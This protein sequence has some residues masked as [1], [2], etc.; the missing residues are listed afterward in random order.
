M[1]TIAFYVAH[2][3]FRGTGNAIYN[4]AHYNEELLNNK[5]IIIYASLY[6]QFDNKNVFDMFKNRFDMYYFKCEED[7]KNICSLLLLD[8][9]YFLC[10]GE[11]SH[12][13]S[14]I[15]KKYVKTLGHFVF[16]TNAIESFTKCATISECISSKSN[17][18]YIYHIVNL[19]NHSYDLREEL[20]I[21]KSSIVLGRLGGYET[22]DIQY[23]FEAIDYIVENYSNIYFIFA[24]S[25]LKY[26]REHPN[27]KYIDIIVDPCI[28][29]KFINTCDAMIHARKDG[30]SF[31]ISVLEFIYCNKP[32][33]TTF[34]KD[35]QHIINL[36]DNAVIYAN[37][38]DLINKITSFKKVKNNINISDEFSPLNVMNKFNKIFLN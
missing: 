9:I 21:P 10:S 14:N 23:V 38:N 18:P 35:N 22:F 5:S 24:P 16:E 8:Y 34:G 25:L 28:K 6:P 2:F 19:P 1:K 26:K 33:F 15:C 17:L 29:R 37:K 4:Y 7:I 13:I 12:N 31:G 11:E 27:I 32:V 30:E 20:N 36:K 3:D